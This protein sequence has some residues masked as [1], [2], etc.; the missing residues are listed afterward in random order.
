MPVLIGDLEGVRA[1]LWGEMIASATTPVASPAVPQVEERGYLS[2]QEVAAVMKQTDEFVRDH[3][4]TFGG[5]A[6]RIS[7]IEMSSLVS[8]CHGR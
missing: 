4:D 8:G 6:R 2:V 1:S 7:A 3:A 5:S